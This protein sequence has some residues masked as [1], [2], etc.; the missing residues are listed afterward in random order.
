MVSSRACDDQVVV[1]PAQDCVL[2]AVNHVRCLNSSQL[3][4]GVYC[5]R[6]IVTGDHVG[7]V[8]DIDVVVANTTEHEVRVDSCHD[9]VVATISR[10]DACQG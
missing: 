5:R 8:A 3:T 2:A 9:R 6:S 1:H 7:P 10:T 4:G